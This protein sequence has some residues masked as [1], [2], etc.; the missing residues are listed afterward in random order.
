MLNMIQE[1]YPSILDKMSLI[2]GTSTGSFI[3]IGIAY[4][5]TPK[6]I[7]NIYTGD[8]GKQ[9]FGKSSPGIIMSKYETDDKWEPIFYNNLPGSDNENSRVIDV[10]LASS[11]A[12]IYFPIY[13]N[14]VDGGVIANDTSLV[15]LIHALDCGLAKS[16][17]NIKLISIGTG[18]LNKKIS[19]EKSNWG[20]IDWIINKEV[21]YP[22]INLILESNSKFSQYC[23]K[24]Y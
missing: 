21:S 13:N 24:K 12:P 6:D 14:H 5:L 18:D 2:G 9:V 16:I 8:G 15:C 1:H 17:S 10:M 7:L 20:A 19:I 23:I 11:A 3:A 22:I 4:G